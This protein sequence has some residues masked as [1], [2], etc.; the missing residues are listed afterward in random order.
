LASER[1]K[2]GYIGMVTPNKGVETLARAAAQLGDAALIDYVIAGDGSAAY[3]QKISA[4]FPKGRA[5]FLGWVDPASFYPAIDVL[6]VP[7][8]WGEPF[9]RVC[10]EA[11]AHGVAVVVAR[12]GA[13][14]EI[15]E[16]GKSGLSFRAGDHLA[17]ADSLRTL[18]RDRALLSRLQA[19]AIERVN[20]FNPEQ[21]GLAFEEFLS[22]ISDHSSHQPLNLKHAAER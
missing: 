2:V 20:H 5:R 9:G 8:L 1:I 14:P 22:G 21:L 7:S 17:L 18:A 19:G 10:I 13:L 4:L 11:F 15:I 6:V 16:V 3:T 12:S